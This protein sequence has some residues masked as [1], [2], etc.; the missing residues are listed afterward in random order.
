MASILVL[1]GP[2]LNLL[3]RREPH[4]YGTM[5]LD[6]IEQR[7]RTQANASRVAID[8]LQTNHEGVMIDHIHSVLDQPP[9]VI[10]INPGA[11]T[12]SSV[13]IRDALSAI[14]CPFVE[15]HLTNIHSREPFR[16]HSYFSDKALAV[17]A[18]CG[19][20]G[21]EL[22]MITLLANLNQG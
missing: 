22:A 16:A 21:Y 9:S 12:H 19:A 2:N 5:T 15:V 20:F 11:W 18:G 1:N 6:D 4:L 8:W 14:E 13:A 10:I 3:G 7:V 17:I